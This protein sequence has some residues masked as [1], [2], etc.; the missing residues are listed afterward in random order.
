MYLI[1]AFDRWVFHRYDC[2]WSLYSVTRKSELQSSTRYRARWLMAFHYR[3]FCETIICRGVHVNGRTILLANYSARYSA[4]SIR[5]HFTRDAAMLFFSGSGERSFPESA[6]RSNSTHRRVSGQAGR[7]RERRTRVKANG[8]KGR[9]VK[10]HGVSPLSLEKI[11]IRACVHVPCI[12]ARACTR[13]HTRSR[14][15]GT[16][17]TRGRTEWNR[18]PKRERDL[19]ILPAAW[20]DSANNCNDTVKPLGLFNGELTRMQLVAQRGAFRVK[21][22]HI[23]E[24]RELKY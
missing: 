3:F 10:S 24:S 20:L 13:L 16:R 8:Q 17:G 4:N 2:R 9:P 22:K 23:G 15:R 7:G 6:R 1:T 21:A 5:I 12:C 11:R 19:R 14:M 18:I